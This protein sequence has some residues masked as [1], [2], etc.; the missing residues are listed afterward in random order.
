MKS[1]HITCCAHP[2]SFYLLQLL[3]ADFLQRP[4]LYFHRV[5]RLLMRKTQCVAS[6]QFSQ[7]I[8]LELLLRLII[9]RKQSTSSPCV[10]TCTKIRQNILSSQS[11]GKQCAILLADILWKRRKLNSL[12]TRSERVGSKPADD[13]LLMLKRGIFAPRGIGS[14][15]WFTFTLLPFGVTMVQSSLKR[16]FVLKVVQQTGDF[17]F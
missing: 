10:H 8:P 15:G 13:T 6:L 1:Q 2:V 5:A 9:H 4:H 11:Y 12:G 7:T 17:C 16:D 3:F 14:S